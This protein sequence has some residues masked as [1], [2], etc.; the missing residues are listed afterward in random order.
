MDIIWR[1]MYKFEAE[2]RKLSVGFF[3]VIYTFDGLL[4]SSAEGGEE[5]HTIP[6]IQKIM[7]ELVF[8]LVVPACHYHS[9]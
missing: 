1:G 9:M 6:S 4:L 5:I 8:N 7:E 2:I 3:L